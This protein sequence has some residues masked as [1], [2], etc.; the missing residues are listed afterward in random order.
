MF[1]LARRPRIRQVAPYL[2]RRQMLGAR[3]RLCKGA[4]AVPCGLPPTPAW[5]DAPN[6]L[7]FYG[8]W[9]RWPQEAGGVR[10]ATPR[11]AKPMARL[12][13]TGTSVILNDRWFHPVSY[14]VL[15]SRSIS[16]T[17]HCARRR[18][19]LA[20]RWMRFKIPD[21]PRSS[22][23]R[24][25]DSRRASR[26]ATPNIQPSTCATVRSGGVRSGLSKPARRAV[27]VRKV[28]RSARDEGA[29]VEPT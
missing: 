18:S 21:R 25:G 3:P 13:R 11:R 2:A 22:P 12:D 17:I 16:R 4:G 5:G 20:R 1:E 6:A 15:G 26:Y 29:G 10:G 27:R 14:P 19:D 8:V 24:H 23:S 28:A 9:G 7:L